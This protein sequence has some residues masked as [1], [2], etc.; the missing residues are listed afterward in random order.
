MYTNYNH[1]YP[2]CSA[3]KWV[4]PRSHIDSLLSINSCM[5][6]GPTQTRARQH[7]AYTWNEKGSATAKRINILWINPN[8]TE[9]SASHTRDS[10]RENPR[11]SQDAGRHSHRPQHPPRTNNPSRL[12]PPPSLAHIVA[13]EERPRYSQPLLFPVR[14][15]K[16][17][18][19]TLNLKLF[20]YF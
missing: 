19:R 11:L 12:P 3:G 17:N 18:S 7:R 6:T 1:F 9:A 4:D 20:G 5:R 8:L 14:C 16:L 2:W 15:A 13:G 10:G